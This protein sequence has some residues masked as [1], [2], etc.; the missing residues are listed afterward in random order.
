M[1][2][3]QVLPS[4]LCHDIMS[5]YL[6]CRWSPWVMVQSSPR[7]ISRSSETSTHY[8]SGSAP[9]D[10]LDNFASLSP[11]LCACGAIDACNSWDLFNSCNETA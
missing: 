1:P 6:F 9:I 5:A 7:A 8:G 3:R 10:V 4:C 2:V 11:M